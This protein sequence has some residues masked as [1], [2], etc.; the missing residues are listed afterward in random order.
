G[1]LINKFLNNRFLTDVVWPY[2]EPVSLARTASFVSYSATLL[3]IMTTVNSY[4]DWS[5][6]DAPCPVNNLL[7]K[8]YEFFLRVLRT[9]AQVAQLSCQR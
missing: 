8:G 7:Q 4:Q 2:N 9:N 5:L 6:G 1:C 3:G